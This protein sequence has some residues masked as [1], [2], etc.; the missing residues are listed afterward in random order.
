MGARLAGR[1][2]RDHARLGRDVRRERLAH[3]RGDIREG[4]S[5]HAQM[6]GHMLALTEQYTQRGKG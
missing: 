4:T 1:S 2:L 6:I 3:F 5:T